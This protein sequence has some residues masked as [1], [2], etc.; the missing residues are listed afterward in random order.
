MP[1]RWIA[2]ALGLIGLAV[3][4]AA[5]AQTTVIAPNGGRI[6]IARMYQ[7]GQ[8][9]AKRESPTSIGAGLAALKPTY[10]PT[11]LRFSA[12]QKVR[13]REVRGWNT[14]V[15]AVRQ[16]SPDA[17]F[18]V[19]LN[20]LEY[21]TAAKVRRMMA[22]VRA[23]VNP[24]GWL[25]DFYTPAARK[26]PK[27]IR[28]AIAYAH[29]NGEF[30]G[31]NAFGIANDPP[32]PAGTDYIAVQDTNFHINFPAVRRLAART[33]VF[34]HL[35]NSPNLNYSDGCKFIEDYSTP[36]RIAY[37]RMRAS[38]Q[39]ANHFRFAYPVLFPECERNRGHAEATIFT[40]N[41]FRDEPMIDAI[42]GLMDQYEPP[43]LPTPAP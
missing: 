22:R 12:G 7:D 43:T 19:E 5:A 34:F 14:V 39:E 41:A 40:Y 6:A 11:L 3:P 20:A 24:D 35:G 18:S 29:A 4:Q 9:T 30:M 8:F 2:I 31:G 1:A 23:A 42:S 36:K 33:T 37:V 27:V 38:Q 13:P 32:V 16:T 21:P 15:A 28:A 17:Q 26:K 25:F 10:V